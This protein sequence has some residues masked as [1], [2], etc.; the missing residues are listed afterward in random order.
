MTVGF[1]V[2]RACE[3]SLLPEQHH[4]LIEQLWSH[5]AVGIIG[6]EP[7]SCKSFLA[8]GMAVAVASGCPCLGRFKV[9]QAGAVLLFAAEDALHIVRARLDGICAFQGIDLHTLNLWVITVPAIRLDQ[10]RDIALLDKTVQRFCPTLLVLDPLVRMHRVDENQ[11]AQIAPLL[12][13]LR[14]IQRK[15]KCAVVLVHHTRKNASAARAGQALRGSSELHAW[16]DSNLY[17]HRNKRRLWLSMEHRA[18]PSHQPFALR[19]HTDDEAIALLADNSDH[20]QDDLQHNDPISHNLS[21]QQRVIEALNRFHQPVRLR[22]LRNSCRIRAQSLSAALDE[23]VESGQVLRTQQ[24]W[25]LANR[26]ADQPVDNLTADC[27]QLHNPG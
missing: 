26:I 12:A 4:W 23:L 16:G 22:A 8:L 21:A 27:F 17:V 10:D 11:S 25:I 13:S 24:G 6:G 14:D 15:Y 18:Q 7:K 3:I 2:Q 20:D 1:S 5:E 9:P 19:L